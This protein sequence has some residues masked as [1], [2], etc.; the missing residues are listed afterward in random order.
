MEYFQHYAFFSCL[1][2]L[3]KTFCSVTC[4]K[5]TLAAPDV[6]PGKNVNNNERESQVSKSLNPPSVFSHKGTRRCL[7]PQPKKME[8]QIT[9]ITQINKKI[10]SKKWGEN[11][12]LKSIVMNRFPVAGQNILAKKAK[13]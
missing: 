13:N 9:Q 1:L 6:F 7:W 3:D 4:S 2:I 12:C 5:C 8:P 10:L 11:F